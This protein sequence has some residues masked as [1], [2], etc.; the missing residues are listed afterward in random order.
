MSV[1]A[2]AARPLQPAQATSARPPLRLG[3]RAPIVGRMQQLLV[4]AGFRPGV[5]DGYFGPQTLAAVRAF[6]RARGLKVD[7][8]VGPITWAALER[9]PATGAPPASG[10]PRNVPFYS[11]MRAPNGY[12]NYA[13]GPTSLAMVM[14][15]EGRPPASVL[16]V[17]LRAG[18]LRSSAGTSHD[19]LIRAARTYGFTPRTGSGWNELARSLSSGHP[20]V[21]HIDTTP[22]R[23]RPYGY[24]G[25]HYVVIT[26]LVH[27]ARG[28]V[29]QV[30]CND[31]ATS[32]AS[33]GQGIRYSFA[34]FERAW[35]AKNKWFL[36]TR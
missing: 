15:A 17:A 14:A 22:L 23:N 30:I 3:A 2:I 19:G 5:I 27:D 4:R 31:P 11:Q 28:R 7:G 10:T 35:G 33:R 34:D 8:F 21:A 6:Q 25:G 16:Q 18:T 24:G 26:G 32:Y 12:A 1:A 29:T 20:V 36:S 13:C 9:T